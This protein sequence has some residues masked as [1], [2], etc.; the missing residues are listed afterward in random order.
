MP[1]LAVLD[2]WVNYRMRFNRSNVET[3]PDVFVVTDQYA[4]DLATAEFGNAY[5][6][7]MWENRYLQ[8]EVANVRKHS[9][10]V[11]ANPPARLLVVLEPI[12]ADWLDASAGAPELRALD[13][14]MVNLPAI[15]PN[16]R[17][18]LVRLRPHPS[19]PASKYLPWVRRQ[20]N[21]RIEISDAPSL[22]ADVAWCD[23]AAGLES[24]A[25][26]V[27]LESGRRAVS[28]LPP[29][30]PRCSLRH[31]RLEHLQQLIKIAS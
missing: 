2:H 6:V 1:V 26:I 9:E 22:A 13:H 3:L 16:P 10:R 19:E 23:M 31:S 25:L 27:A 24:Y 15:S 29:G 28:Y 17:E 8:M 12:R 30:A 11:V 7:V 5:P 18:V 4:A 21:A 14:L 20:S